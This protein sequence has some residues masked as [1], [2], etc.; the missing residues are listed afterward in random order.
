MDVRRV[1]L[2]WVAL[3][4]IVAFAASHM[5]SHLVS[6]GSSDYADNTSYTKSAWKTGTKANRLST[7]KPSVSLT[8]A[9]DQ[10]GIPIFH[11]RIGD[12]VNILFYYT[13]RY[14][15]DKQ[16]NEQRETTP[17][18]FIYRALFPADFGASSPTQ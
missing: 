15:D 11:D 5:V 1:K 6:G 12:R 3:A 7:V 17:L 13:E 18:V 10:I 2:G 9:L 4:V 14:L 8:K 16:A